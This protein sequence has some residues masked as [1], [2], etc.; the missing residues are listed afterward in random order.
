M[1]LAILTDEAALRIKCEDVLPEEIEPLKQQLEEALAASA[2]QGRPGIGLAAPQV[3]IGKKLAIVRLPGVAID[4]INCDRVTKGYDKHL[5]VGEG[6]LSF[7]DRY[8]S[9]FRYREIFV[10]GN[11][12]DPK[13]FTA[14]GLTA[15][16]VQHELDHLRGV[17]LPDVAV[18]KKAKRKARPNDP[19]P[20]QS[21]RK[22]KRCCGA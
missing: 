14:R 2:E 17:L 11:E 21:G 15:I 22:Y 10:D 3:G 20:C 9:T 5:F 6:C 1:P 7:P 16:A 8:E 13:R 19:C 12:G 4:L 18:K